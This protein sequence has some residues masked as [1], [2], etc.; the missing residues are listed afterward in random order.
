MMKY[1]LATASAVALLAGSAVAFDSYDQ[2]KAKL[3]LNGE[4]DV[5]CAITINGSADDVWTV[6]M[7]G[8]RLNP[9]Y[10]QQLAYGCNAPYTVTLESANGGLLNK[11]AEDQG[12]IIKYHYGVSFGTLTATTDGGG[13]VA[14]GTIRGLNQYELGLTEGNPKEIDS[15]DWA[16]IAAIDAT[17]GGAY[18]DPYSY[19]LT[20]QKHPVGIE[21]DNSGRV[22][23]K[24][25]DT[26]TFTIASAL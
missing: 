23:G 8:N 6:N 24:Y 3:K 15:A 4:I 26:L 12:A 13:P 16:D 14:P 21:P 10:N 17:G 18:G 22:A 11:T 9:Q 20:A 25:K 1:A 19:Y 5:Q 7:D 2:A